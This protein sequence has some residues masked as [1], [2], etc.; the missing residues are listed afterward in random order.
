MRRIKKKELRNIVKRIKN[1][2]NDKFKRQVN[3]YIF[4]F[5]LLNSF[6]FLL[7]Q[8]QLSQRSISEVA[9]LQKL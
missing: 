5:G 7:F 8:E 6:S 1:I 9:I 4:K 2:L 3:K